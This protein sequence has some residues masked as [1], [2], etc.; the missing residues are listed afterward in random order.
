M[1]NIFGAALLAASF[2][3]GSVASAAVLSV[4]GN[5][6]VIGTPSS[7]TNAA[8]SSSTSMLVFNEVQNLILGSDIT[9]ST[10]TILAGARVNSQMV[11]L[12]RTRSNGLLSLNGTVSFDGLILGFI[13]S[14]AGLAATDA[15]LGAVGTT[16]EQF[17]LRGLEGNET[18]SG[19]GTSTL[20]LNLIVR[21]PGDWMRVVTVAAVPVPAAGF[22]LFGA[23]GGLAALRRRK[24]MAV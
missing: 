20:A 24:A 5:V 10:G 12:N 11:L 1:K 9:T 14:T 23:L 18:V 21:Q 15:I 3:T 16:Y 19:Q 6:S 7:V 2:F 4:T 17:V 22:L 13:T 8:P